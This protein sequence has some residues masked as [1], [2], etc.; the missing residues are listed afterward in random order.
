MGHGALQSYQDLVFWQRGME[1]AAE[2]YELT[3]Q[4]PK[5]EMYGMVSE[6]VLIFV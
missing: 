1:L 5:T 6:S 3:R 2:W 4:F